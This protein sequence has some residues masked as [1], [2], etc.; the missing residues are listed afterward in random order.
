MVVKF[1]H[2][3]D[4]LFIWEF[5]TTLDYEWSVIRGRRPYR[6]TIW[7]HSLTRVAALLAVIVNMIGFDAASP[8]NCQAWVIF[9]VL[10]AYIAIA[11]ASMLLVLRTIAIWNRDKIVYTIVVC[12]WSTNVSFLIHS[13]VQIRSSWEP[14]LNTCSVLN[15]DSSKYNIPIT[16]A[17]D[18][19][20][21]FTMLI[22]LFR[23][24]L[25]VGTS[26][27]GR[28]LWTQG[29]IWFLLATM[30]QLPAAVLILLDLNPPLNL[31]FQTPAMVTLIIAATRMYRALTD[32]CSPDIS[33]DIPQTRVVSSTQ[34]MSPRFFP[35]KRVEVVTHT[36]SGQYP[37]SQASH[38]DL[39]ASTD[40]N[41]CEKPHGL[42]NEG[43]IE[44]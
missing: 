17:T 2:T 12:I 7:V 18:V 28:V 42:G 6:W 22:G 35:M 38:Y 36:D 31:M 3:V 19:I 9:E 16:L 15:T 23:L 20:L 1:W 32:F 39:H 43:D 34:Q 29:V 8:I 40:M 44:S 25:G 21:F 27:L 26:V 11:G 33:Q 4:G 10:F 14:V 5:V 24:R 30:V 13:I 41:V 37:E